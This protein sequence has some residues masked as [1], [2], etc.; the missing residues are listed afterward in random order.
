MPSAA[1][2]VRPG[3]RLADLNAMPSEPLLGG[4]TVIHRTPPRVAASETSPAPVAAW[5]FW[6]GER[7][8]DTAVPLSGRPYAMAA[9]VALAR[10]PSVPGS[11]AF[12]QGD[13]PVNVARAF[14][15]R[16]LP[17]LA[18][19]G[20]D[21]DAVGSINPAAAAVPLPVPAPGRPRLASLPPAS[22]PGVADDGDLLRTAFYDI[23]AR[24]VYLPNGEKL[25]AHSG[26]GSLMDDPRS[27][28][29]KMRGPTPP[30]VYRLRLRERLFHG[31]QAIRLI[32][33]DE[34]A[35]FRRN[36]MLAHTYMLG[37]NGQSNGCVSFKNYPRFLNAFLRGEVNRLV[38]V[39][40][41]DRPPGFHNRN[42]PAIARLQR[43]RTAE[44]LAY[45]DDTAGSSKHSNIAASIGSWLSSFASARP[46]ASTR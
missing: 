6:R 41:L 17:R 40:K 24:T 14:V 43:D 10:A 20:D 18:D 3:E 4:V 32:P 13:R 30:N 28:R 16:T 38:V 31:V 19:A 7:V 34:D 42:A 5:L 8:A 23:S 21:A 1:G 44:R 22:E 39:A 35:M 37:P 12:A 15:P 29:V 45:S 26:L 36:G 9:G 25:E 2:L 11:A 27:V 33:E 46:S